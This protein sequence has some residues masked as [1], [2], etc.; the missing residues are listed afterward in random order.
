M[1]KLNYEYQSREQAFDFTSDAASG[2]IDEP[3][4][5]YPQ[6]THIASYYNP[7]TIQ[8]LLAFLTPQNCIYTIMASPEL[9]QMTPDKK[10]QWNGGEY[11]LK[12]LPQSAL[13][14]WQSTKPSAE[15]ALPAPNPYIPSTLT[16]VHQ[17]APSKKE[18]IP[19]LLTENNLGKNY[20]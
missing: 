16:L 5:T 15:I 19:L 4:S 11:T 7:K 13:L 12:N 8:S 17:D 9:T 2:L 6:K 18:P 3:L 1:A 20:F 10:E 14:A